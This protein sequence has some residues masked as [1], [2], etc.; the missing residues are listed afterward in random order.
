VL[1][2]GDTTPAGAALDR[3]FGDVPSSEACRLWERRAT[4]AGESAWSFCPSIAE[5]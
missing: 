3:H 5:G 4:N 1:A 2:A